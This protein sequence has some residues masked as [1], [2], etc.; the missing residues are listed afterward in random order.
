MTIKVLEKVKG[1]MPQ[2]S[3]NGDMID[4][5]TAEEVTLKAPYVRTLHR[6]KT[7]N[8]K[9]NITRDVVYDS[10]IVSLGVAM[11][12]PKGCEAVVI[13]RSSTFKKWSVV[14]VNSQGEIDNIYNGK[15]DIWK[16]PIIAFRNVT[17]PKGTRLCQFRVQLSQKATVWQKIKWLFS[18]SIKLKQVSSLGDNNRGGFG[19]SGN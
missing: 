5:Y 6:L 18:S 9:I 3:A 10:A 11:E 2:I 4:L 15:D 12:L 7:D 13:P 14:Q 19:T 17:I 1:C 16:M 8:D